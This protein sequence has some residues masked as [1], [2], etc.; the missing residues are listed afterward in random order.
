MIN[1][2]DASGDDV[3]GVTIAPDPSP[4]GGGALNCDGTFSGSNI[5]ADPTW[6]PDRTTPMYLAYYDADAEIEITLLSLSAWTSSLLMLTI[7]FS[8]SAVSP[9]R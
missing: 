1:V 3:A 7:A 6:V 4:S 5:T 8:K 9:A 2:Q